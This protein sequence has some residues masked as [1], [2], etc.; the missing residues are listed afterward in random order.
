M[1]ILLFIH[2]IF[3]ITGITYVY[4]AVYYFTADIDDYK[5]FDNRK[6]I[7]GNYKPWPISENYNKVTMAPGLKDLLGSM[8]TVS[9]LVVKN[10]AIIYEKYWDDYSD[11]SR[12]N[13]FSMAKTIIGILTGIAIK[14]GKIKDL[15]QP[16][17]N[18]LP[19]FNEGKK[20]KITIKHLLTM[21]SGLNWQESYLMPVSHTTE[22]YYGSD[23]WKL[24]QKLKVVKPP[25]TEFRYK[26][27]DT[28]LMAF[29]LQ[30]ATNSSISDYASEKLWR[31]LNAK[32]NGLWSLDHENGME[33]AYCCFN[34][35]ARDF[36]RIGQLYLQNG[37][38]NGTQLVQESYVKS[39]TTP[40]NLI[41]N[42]GKEVS[43]FGYYWW[44]A[45]YDGHPIYYARGILGQYIIVIP[46]IDVV[47]VRLG[48]N[49]GERSG[50]HFEEIFAIAKAMFNQ[51]Q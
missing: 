36:A 49:R 14:E 28:Q 3:E 15:N 38:W 37:Y 2:L 1:V 30:E 34:S 19:E 4:R 46:D 9:F 13:S 39:S 29:V 33:K 27:G 12:S 7:A 50:Y 5:I 20:A 47:A 25:G 40:P 51:Y 23:L 6:V 41:N 22:A 45:N 26:S 32:H 10:G 48:H 44:L 43:Y 16:V 8:N 24:I 42:F 35:N 18:F 17:G 11:S 31:P 21:S